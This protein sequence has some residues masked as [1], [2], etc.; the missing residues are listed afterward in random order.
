MKTE[1]LLLD[2]TMVGLVFIP[3]LVLILVGR[4]NTKNLKKAFLAEAKSGGFNFDETGKW[5][6]N[7]IGLDRKQRKLLFVQNNSDGIVVKVADL[8]TVKENRLILE[9]TPGKVSGKMA[10]VLERI[11]LELRNSNGHVQEVIRLY[12]VNAVYSQEYELKN[13]EH[14]N[15]LVRNLLVSKPAVSS[16]A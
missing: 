9:R 12:D 15:T 13:A 10:D 7:M 3:Y 4:A 5:N 6:H 2:L 14:W 8:S 11:S 16:A 1:M